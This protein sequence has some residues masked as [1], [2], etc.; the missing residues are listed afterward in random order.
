V[1]LFL[2]VLFLN[3]P[4]KFK[5]SRNSRWPEKTKSGTLYYPYWL[6][7]CAGLCAEKDIDVGLFDC[8]AKGYSLTDTVNAIGEGRP[9]FIVAEITTPTCYDDF[10]AI[11]EI[12]ARFPH[13][14]IIVGG[15]HATALPEQ[16]LRE[17]PG[18]DVVVR[19]EYEYS[20]L[21][22]VSGVPLR[23]VLGV[24]FVSGG[25]VVHTPDR[26]FSVNL[27]ELPFVSKVYKRFLDVGDYFYAFTQHPMIQIFSSRGCPFRCDFCSYPETMGGRQFRKRSVVNFVDEIEFIC[28]SMREVREIFIEDDTF[29]VDLNRV[30]EICD[31][32]IRRGLKP[33]WSC[34]ARVDVPYEVLAK[35]KSAGC[36][37]LVVGY[38]SGSQAVLDEICKGITLEQSLEFA[39]NTKRLRLKVFGC[40]MIGLTGDSLERIEETFSF[41]K[42]VYPDMVFFQ[43]AVPFPGSAFYSWVR[44][45]GYLVTEDYSEWLD[46][47]GYLRCLV[48]YPYASPE[49]IEKLRD[50]LM[51]RYYFSFTYVFRTFLANLSWHEFRRVVTA[52]VTYV[53]FRLRRRRR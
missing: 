15:T 43:Q 13:V 9:E 26:V 8:I 32:I 52:G 42:A 24:S 48:N 35:M 37:L 5:V 4:Y 18:I 49:E 12:K 29:T 14:T 16:V 47:D 2:K 10:A 46:E 51:S 27:D 33:V 25:E 22:I 31:E 34:N 45:R 3:L 20:V 53:S 40:F 6:A 30:V 39:R 23:D 19:H 17:C 1:G 11:A 21:E 36:R 28:T 50:R 41:A 38:E 44:E 7:Y